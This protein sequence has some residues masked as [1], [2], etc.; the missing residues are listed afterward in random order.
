MCY[1]ILPKSG[2]AIA[3]TTVQRISQDESATDAVRDEIRQY[4]LSIK[5]KIGDSVTDADAPAPPLGITPQAHFQQ[6]EDGDPP[7]EG[8]GGPGFVPY[9]P[10]STMP[11][12]DDFDAD[13]FD[14]YI[15]AQ[16][17]LP[18]GDGYVSGKVVTRK[19]DLDG[20]PVGVRN[21]NPILDTRVYNVEFP[22]GHVSEY[23]ANVIAECIY[24]QVDEEG[25]QYAILSEIV[26]H[27]SDGQAVLPA[28]MWIAGDG[29]RNRHMRRTTKGWKLCVSWKDGTTSW[30]TLS[31]LKESNPVQVAE[32]AV[33]NKIDDAPA[34]AWWVK[35]VLRRRERIIHAVRS[36][37]LK[38][39][40]KFGIEIPKTVTDALQIDRDTNTTFWHEALLKEMKNVQTAFEFHDVGTKAPVGY[41]WIPL[42]LIFDV[43]MDFTRKVRLVAG[44]HVT[45]PPT[46]ITYSSV[47]SRESVR[48]AFL[49]AALNDLEVLS[50]DIGNAYLNA[51]T[52]EKVYT[53]AG[54]EF[55]SRE[56]QTVLIVRALYG[57]KS[58]GAAWRAHLAQSLRDLL[59]IPSYADGDVW[60]REATKPDGFAYY[61]YLLVYVD[62]ILCISH[63]PQD[64][65][66]A[67]GKLYRLKDDKIAE[68]A[69]GLPGRHYQATSLQ[70]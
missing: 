58:S 25:R 23:S 27:K 63:K 29:S 22:D 9:D 40:H 26:D 39:T 51:P 38:R 47:V 36:R 59:Y 21:Q 31:N 11:D 64:T 34:F 44:G 53:T 57:L 62:D 50:A 7:D 60:Y 52:R 24:S 28:D 67:I 42:H 5:D 6:D 45:D 41:K 2:V 65:M 14:A 19:H 10:A 61:E 15:S 46:S 17:L 1:W 70:G 16:V 54:K 4:D 32:Y 3:R 56:G 37:Y 8:D 30:E 55:G 66:N 20:N 48:I 35:D 12:A 33:T 68:R 18:E 43:K 13:A 69:Y 49:V